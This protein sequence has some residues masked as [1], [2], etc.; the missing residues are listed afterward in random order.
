[1]SIVTRFPPSP[2]G[3]LHLGG[4]R[5]A[6][7]NWLYARQ[8]GG[9]FILRIED[10]DRERSTPEA[11]QAILDG[12][13]WLGLDYDEGPYYQT[14]RF[15]RYKAVVQQLLEAD[16]AYACDCSPERLEQ[17][18][19]EQ[20]A[21]GGKPRYDG[22]CRHRD[23][24]P[25]PGRVVRFK[26][27]LDGVIG[28]EDLVKGPLSV[29]NSEL[30]DLIIARSDGTPTYN[31]CVVVDD[32]D[33]GMTHILRGDDHVN[34]TPRQ[35]HILHAL[36]GE[37]PRYGHIPMILGPDG[38]RLSK[39]HGA[40]SVLQYRDAG[41]LPQAMRNY[42]ARLGWSHGD[43]EIFSD[44]VL[45]EAF[46]LG[47]IQRSPARFD[48][49]KLGWVNQHWMQNTSQAELDA[50]LSELAQR[51]QLQ[52]QPGPLASAAVRIL[53]SRCK[54]L[55]EFLQ[56]AQFFFEAPTSYN[57]KDWQKQVR[58]EVTPRVVGAFIERLRGLDD[59]TSESL[60]GAAK[61]TVA[62]CEVGFAKLGMPARLALAGQAQAPALDDILLALGMEESCRRLQALVD[63][64][65]GEAS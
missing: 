37:E 57:D 53:A 17:V 31:L 51:E 12:M 33:M 64:V 60:Q 35:L 58:P 10:T 42:L 18:R 22:H 49:D 2:T 32:L 26:T 52:W 54:T 16:Q 34:N 24:E 59:W 27:P 11:V 47:N 28:W 38:K 50:A 3:Y 7:Y 30:D 19:A 9:K 29:A 43:E 15:D 41:Y 48:M 4:A 36:G 6:L 13:V 25:G 55:R 62:Q 61:D 23:L 5:T 56:Q 14:E 65:L 40:V 44:E 20:M 39:R 1:M 63:R 21:K 8:H 45:I 46:S